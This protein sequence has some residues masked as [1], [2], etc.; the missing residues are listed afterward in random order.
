MFNFLAIPLT[1]VSVVYVGTFTGVATIFLLEDPAFFAIPRDEIGRA[2]NDAIFYS[3]APGLI[4]NI[5][6]GYIYD[7]VGRRWTMSGGVFVAA[8]LAVLIPYTA[9]SLVYFTILRAFMLMGMSVLGCH[10]LVNDYVTKSTRGRALAL[11]SSGVFIGDILTFVIML[12]ATRHLSPYGR[13]QVFAFTIFLISLLFFF[14]VKEPK[15]KLKKVDERPMGVKVRELTSQVVTLCKSDILF[16]IC[17]F[18]TMTARTIHSLFG[19]FL[20]LYVTKEFPV[21]ADAEVV[22]Q[23]ANIFSVIVALI[24][25]FPAGSLADKIQARYLIPCAFFISSAGLVLFQL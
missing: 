1:L 8:C 9:P 7:L 25:V 6:A 11:Q 5:L 10:P 14:S 15:F 21:Q 18:G 13:F 16:P 2:T 23:N 24:V 22:I 17:L 20:M 4:F 19:T 12:N 3:Q